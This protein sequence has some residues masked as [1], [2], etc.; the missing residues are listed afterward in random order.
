M[1]TPDYPKLMARYNTWQNQSLYREAGRLSDAE[2]KANRG[3]FFGSIHG[4]L[5]HLI[6][7]DM[8]WLHRFTGDEAFK[9]PLGSIADSITSVP[10]W[11]DLVARRAALDARI[12]R[13]ADTLTPE[14]LAGDLTYHS[15]ATGKTH[16]KPRWAMIAHMFNH[17]TH[18]RGQVHAM[19]TACGLAPDDTDIP[20]IVDGV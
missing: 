10:N 4:T 6:W 16:A 5:T 2:R 13:W 14:T 20:M 17:Q 12:E 7:G 8:A 18:H 3:A 9:L 1:I 19:L 15:V 11:D